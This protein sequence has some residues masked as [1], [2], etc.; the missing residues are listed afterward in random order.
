M[1]ESLLS[2]V[3]PKSL[4]D[5]VQFLLF[6]KMNVFSFS[7]L[8][9]NWHNIIVYITRN[10]SRIY[11]SSTWLHDP[12]LLLYLWYEWPNCKVETILQDLPTCSVDA[13]GWTQS[14][15]TSVMTQL[16]LKPAL[17]KHAI[18]LDCRYPLRW[19]RPSG[20]TRSIW[21]GEEFFW[22]VN[23]SADYVQGSNH[24][25]MMS[26]KKNLKYFFYIFPT[27]CRQVLI[28]FYIVW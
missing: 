3:P 1:Y 11:L 13:S 20:Y 5:L 28:P 16:H 25:Q 6:P 26:V 19:A 2:L 18:S 8:V 22:G 24:E 23:S 7:H 21:N 15:L 10:N 9:I 27:V 12:L 17:F 14:K 4:I